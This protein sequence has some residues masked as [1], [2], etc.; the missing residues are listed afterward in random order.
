M[1][2]NISILPA[3]QCTGCKACSDCCPKG[4]ISFEKDTEGFFYPVVD[5]SIC[6]SCSVCSKNCPALNPR[7]NNAA[8]EATA[9][10]ATESQAKQAGSSGGIFGLIAKAVINNGGKVWGA[11][12]DGNLSLK[13]SCATTVEE[14]KPLMRSKYIQSDTDGCFSQIKKDIIN[15]IPTLFAG[16]PCQVNALLNIIGDNRD[17]LTT[18]EV[19]CHGVPSQDLFNKTIE[20]WE[21]KHDARVRKFSFRS[22]HVGASH[23]HA[24]SLEYACGGYSSVENGLHYQFPYYF[25]F[26]KYITL[27][28][29]CYKC[30]WAR[31]ERCADITLA[32]FWG[33]EKYDKELN[34]K[35][36]VSAILIN[37]KHGKDLFEKIRGDIK[38][39]KYP[40]EYLLENN[41]CLKNPTA[42]K[43]ERNAFFE[44]LKIRPFDDV[45]KMYLMPHRKWIFD[46]Y[47]HIPTFMRK[48]LRKMMDKR[49]KYE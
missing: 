11:A 6:I 4:C 34:A 14:L 48:I 13:H 19:V 24:Y 9:A 2:N 8:T 49:M 43:P 46:L 28:P 22:K 35:D 37:T 25:G 26:Q 47:Y 27:R 23:P 30:L 1:A 3:D 45:V 36:G 10:Y 15:G 20:W 17:K 21:E 40:I 33:I 18:I 5:E 44:D 7:L 42:L 16:T 39:N 41:G 29:S 32:D 12:F 31:P 38:Q